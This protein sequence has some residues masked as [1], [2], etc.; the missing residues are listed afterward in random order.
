[1]AT[2][3]RVQNRRHIAR[4]GA[5]AARYRATLTAADELD[6]PRPPADTCSRDARAARREI[7]RILATASSTLT[8]GDL[9]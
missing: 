5:T 2:T 6:P 1:M 8:I 7:R 4:D 3:T 9:S